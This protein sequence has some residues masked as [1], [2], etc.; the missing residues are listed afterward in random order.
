MTWERKTKYYFAIGGK[1][2]IVSPHWNHLG[3]SSSRPV[4]LQ[5]DVPYIKVSSRCGTSDLIT[6]ISYVRLLTK[7]HILVYACSW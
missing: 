5:K 7:V 6:N 4:E 1:H 3:E 2:D